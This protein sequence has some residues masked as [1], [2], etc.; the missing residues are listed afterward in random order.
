M[1]PDE[2]KA[3]LR[4]AWDAYDCGD[5]QA[6]DAY[7]APGW[8]EHE[9]TDWDGPGRARDEIH[10]EMAEFRIAFPDKRT[11]FIR[12]VAEGEWI[13]ALVRTTA[14]HTGPFRGLEATGARIVNNEMTFHRLDRGQLADMWSHSDEPGYFRQIVAQT[15]IAP[16]PAP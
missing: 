7:L 6:F 10:T 11:E 8:R 13:A 5:V 4:R 12:V 1:K 16:P 14:T 2:A 3:L 15:G 9:V